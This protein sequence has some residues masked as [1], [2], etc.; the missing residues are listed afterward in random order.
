MIKSTEEA[1]KCL[2]YINLERDR[3]LEKCEECDFKP[4]CQ[5][6]LFSIAKHGKEIR[7]RRER[8]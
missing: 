8:R 2:F 3:C 1:T 6:V 5:D 4:F 7:E